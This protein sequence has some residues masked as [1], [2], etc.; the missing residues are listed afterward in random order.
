MGK[1]QIFRISANSIVLLALCLT[2]SRGQEKA[3]G[4]GPV[5]RVGI[6]Q[7][8]AAVSY[9]YG[10]VPT[11]IDFTGTALLPEAKGVAVVR[12]G[13]TEIEATFEKL[14]PPTHFGWQYPTYVLWAVT[15]EGAC[16]NLGELVLQ[17]SN[18]A[19][20]QAATDLQTFALIVT[21]EPYAIVRQPSTMV[22]LENQ[23]RPEIAGR[24]V[25][26]EPNPAL[27]PAIEYKWDMGPAPAETAKASEALD[28]PSRELHEAVN[29]VTIARLANAD[30][31][32]PE[33]LAAAQRALA[34]AE[35]LYD[36][37]GDPK[38]VIQNA[39][40]AVQRGDGART[41]AER[42]RQE[43]GSGANR[44]DAA[45]AGSHGEPTGEGLQPLSR[46]LL[47][48]VVDGAFPAQDTQRGLVITLPDTDFDG[49][50]LLHTIV[51]KLGPVAST[52]T[53]QP[54]L[55]IDVEG[56]MDSAELAS[57][58]RA[59]SVRSALLKAGL[60]GNQISMRG[61]M[62]KPGRPGEERRVQIVISGGAPASPNGPPPDA[63]SVAPPATETVPA[64]AANPEPTRAASPT[65]ANRQSSEVAVVQPPSAPPVAPVTPPPAPAAAPVAQ[66]TPLPAPVAAPVAP[67][68]PPPAAVAAPVPPVT[69]APA[70]AAIPA[71]PVATQSPA[72][73]PQ[74]V[75][76][77]AK[78][79]ASHQAQGRK[80]LQ[81]ERYD[82]A[83]REFTEALTLN[84]SLSLAYNGR[85]YAY[86]RLK[87]Y[88]AAIG[89]FDAAIRLNPVYANAYLNRSA[90]RRALGDKAGAASDAAKVRDLTA[91]TTVRS[92]A[93]GSSPGL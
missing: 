7:K 14:P 56:Y 84:P 30:R 33:P 76:A 19:R 44:E 13:H 3:N 81:E 24:V 67:T 82:D 18:R 63:A 49:A 68:T 41:I 65:T 73:T 16:Q 70:P 31:F 69:P 79:A 78:A 9:P 21:A 64:V 51:Q 35:D 50:A 53:T 43:P 38:L 8:L 42:R 62:T 80:F 93:S 61:G 55:H 90:C 86:Y 1:G 36:A 60:Q 85:G 11:K 6:D 74:S 48:E 39:R 88:Q 10:S 2:S 28:R 57:W 58:D 23:A 12:S 40:E 54:N 37:K 91:T 26:V 15:P 72:P 29:A 17:E 83:I 20:L 45:G 27:K 22:V 89:D 46:S 32:A 75:M 4:T 34:Q 92:A 71:A 47:H 87:N 52:L 25:V 77:P 5:Y 59:E 66:S